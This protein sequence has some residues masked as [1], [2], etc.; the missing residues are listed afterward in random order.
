MADPTLEPCEDCDG[1]TVDWG[2][3]V[4]VCATCE[5]GTLTQRIDRML[6]DDLPPDPRYVPAERPRP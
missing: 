6:V 1:G 2:D 4:T 3:I 5:G